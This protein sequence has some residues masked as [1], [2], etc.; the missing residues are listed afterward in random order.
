[1]TVWK[2]TGP[3][4]GING[5]Y[6]GAYGSC[7]EKSSPVCNC[8]KGFSY[9]YDESGISSYHISEVF[10]GGCSR[11]FQLQ[12]ENTDS[13]FPYYNVGLPRDPVMTSGETSKDCEAACL[14]S[15]NCSAYSY[16]EGQTCSHWFG[17]FFNLR[18]DVPNGRTIYIKLAASEFPSKRNKIA[19]MIGSVVGS[20]VLLVLVL[21][22]IFRW[23]HHIMLSPTN[24]MEGSLVVF[25]YRHLKIY[26]KNFS[27]KLA[28][29]GFGAVYK[30][31]LPDSSVVA[32]KKLERINFRIAENHEQF[33]AEV[34]TLGTIQHINLVGLRGFS[35]D[36]STMMLVYDYMPNGS[37]AS[38]LFKGNDDSNILDWKTR[39]SIALGTARGLAYLHE[40]CRE[41]II[42]Y[43]IKPEN[44]FLDSEF[45]PKVADFGMEKLFGRD[46]NR[47]LT[48]LKGTIGYLA[49]EWISGEAITAKADVYSYG[50]VLFELVSGMRNS[51]RHVCVGHYFPLWVANVINEGGNVAE[52]LDPKLQ[53]NADVEELERVCRVALWCIQNDQSH[54]PTMSHVVYFLEQVLEVNIPPVPRILKVFVDP[55]PEN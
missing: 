12:C 36:K 9:Q 40:N 11:D 37:V 23:R 43:D 51:Q 7:T 32:V 50:M 28:E 24:L 18:Q 53:G 21:F 19:I 47:V 49:P 34:R 16:S 41:C 30:G 39:Y 1:M 15:C 42:H 22:I 29:G 25:T 46:F 31:T 2:Y 5:Y 4:C 26:T 38:H 27:D 17:F 54:R 8:L 3:L 52:L 14:R 13:F 48:T 10:Y 55:D 33:L 35:S 20:S 44:V 6:C 45:R